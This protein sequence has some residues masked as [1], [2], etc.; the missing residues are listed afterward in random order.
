L[1]E[2]LAGSV[3][4]FHPALK[5]NAGYLG[6][7]LALFRDIRTDEPCGVHR[8]FLDSQGCKVD[9]KMLGRAGGAAIKLDPDVTVALGL[10]IGE[11][12][13]TCIA[14]RLGGFRPVWDLGSANAI[15]SFPVLSGIEAI[16]IL[17]E[18]DD[19]G[20][21]DRATKDCSGRWIEEGREA[22][23]VRPLIGADFN[24]LWR[25]VA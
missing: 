4:R 17:S 14:A 16:T 25:E 6:G 19:G 18:V 24:D 22:F 5:I 15:A 9:R 13:E 1:P 23:T 7:M 2:D 3:I 11:G 10:H 21:N 20:A 12:I 8:I